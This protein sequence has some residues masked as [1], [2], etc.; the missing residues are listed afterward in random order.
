MWDFFLNNTT[1]I[2]RLVCEKKEQL[3]IKK[4]SKTVTFSFLSSLL[5]Q[6]VYT[7]NNCHEKAT[8]S[9]YA[10]FVYRLHRKRVF[11][12]VGDQSNKLP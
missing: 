5:I 9:I 1:S 12:T 7:S 11:I 10:A 2:T 8:V 4:F 3:L 6:T